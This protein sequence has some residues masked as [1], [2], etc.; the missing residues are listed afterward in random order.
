MLVKS[1]AE[2]IT[3]RNQ[4]DVIFLDFSTAFDTVSHHKVLF[5]LSSY[6]IGE[7]ITL[8][9]GSILCGR[10][11]RVVMNGEISS[12]VMCFQLFLNDLFLVP[13]FS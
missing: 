5:N 6:G 13:Y 7:Q 4:T 2:S 9:I 1:L 3:S 8:W 10:T 11:Q 12:L